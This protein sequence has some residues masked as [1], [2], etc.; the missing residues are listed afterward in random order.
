[1]EEKIQKIIINNYASKLK[2][3]TLSG[4]MKEV[5]LI[6][7]IGPRYDYIIEDL[8]VHTNRDD[9]FRRT[10]FVNSNEELPKWV[11]EQLVKAFSSYKT[12]AIVYEI[13]EKSG[14]IAIRENGKLIPFYKKFNFKGYKKTTPNIN[15]IN[16]EENLKLISKMTHQEQMKYIAKTSI[17]EFVSSFDIKGFT[18]NVD[19]IGIVGDR[20]EFLE[21]KNRRISSFVDKMNIGEYQMYR[22]IQEN[23]FIVRLFTFKE[24]GNSHYWFENLPYFYTWNEIKNDENLTQIQNK[25]TSFN[26]NREQK[27]HTMKLDK[28]KK[29]E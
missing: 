5:E 16:L 1:M 15:E 21:M 19:A 20:V 11:H 4:C 25:R 2:T 29:V 18:L 22:G 3:T 6:R 27:T 9:N 14:V 10:V 26:G 28:Y 12:I 17:Q 7:K 23:G 13:V 24:Y 8:W